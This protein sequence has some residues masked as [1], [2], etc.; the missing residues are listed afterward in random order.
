MNSINCESRDYRDSQKGHIVRW[1]AV[2]GVMQTRFLISVVTKYFRQ[3]ILCLRPRVSAFRRKLMVSANAARY[4]ST[5]DA[6]R[7][8]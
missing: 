8:E 7:A 4:S 6:G 2:S 1:Q 5:I 3:R